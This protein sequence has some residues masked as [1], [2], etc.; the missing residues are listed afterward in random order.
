MRARGV[1]KYSPLFVCL[2]ASRGRNLFVTQYAVWFGFKWERGSK[3]ASGR[4]SRVGVEDGWGQVWGQKSVFFMLQ[5]RSRC[6]WDYTASV[7]THPTAPPPSSRTHTHTHT[8]TQRGLEKF[9]SALNCSY[10][11]RASKKQ[12][13]LMGC[14]AAPWLNWPLSSFQTRAKWIVWKYITHVKSWTNLSVAH[15]V[16]K[17]QSKNVKNT[18]THARADT[19]I[20]FGDYWNAFVVKQLLE[21]DVHGSFSHRILMYCFVKVNLNLDLYVF[22]LLFFCLWNSLK[23]CQAGMDFI[24][25]LTK[26]ENVQAFFVFLWESGMR[27]GNLVHEWEEPKY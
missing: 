15:V 12:R 5:I 17:S 11:Y 1:N 18:H 26:H 24:T 19:Q 6:R 4:R 23:Y 9:H 13:W 3:Q 14:A 2:I 20:S 22:L 25:T 27:E 8:H 21:C 7:I 16:L 10:S